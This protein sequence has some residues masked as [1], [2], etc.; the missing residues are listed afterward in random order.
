[1][2]GERLNVQAAAAAVKLG[3]GFMVYCRNIERK[4]TYE[5]G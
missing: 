1:M 5:T 3:T 4:K 2:D